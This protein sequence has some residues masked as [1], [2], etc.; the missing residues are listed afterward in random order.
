MTNLTL[1]QKNIP[2]QCGI[3][4]ECNIG[5]LGS[6]HILIRSTLMEDSVNIISTAA[7]YIKVNEFQWQM[8][9]LK[10]DPWFEPC[11]ETR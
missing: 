7:Y 10:W 5:V 6:R 11:V 2:I 9:T 4:G 1:L 8:R 3:K